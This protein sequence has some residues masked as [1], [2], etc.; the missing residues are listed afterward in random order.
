MGSVPTPSIYANPNNPVI[1]PILALAIYIWSI[2]YRRDDTRRTLFGERKDVESRFSSWLRSVLGDKGDDLLV[3]GIIIIEIGT[4]SF[5]KG[6]AS[7]LSCLT[8][9][10]SA[11]AIYLI[12]EALS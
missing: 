7:F 11:I 1:C 3:M 10:P 5:R 9:G 2:G 4:H 12:P 8:G 6:V